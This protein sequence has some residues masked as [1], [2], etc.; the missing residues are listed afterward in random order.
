MED[1]WL[2]DS[3]R[4]G[5]HEFRY[6][7]QLPLLPSRY[8]IWFSQSVL[9]KNHFLLLVW[10]KEPIETLGRAPFSLTRVALRRAQKLSW[11]PLSG[12]C[13]YHKEKKQC[14][15][16]EATVHQKNLKQASKQS[17]TNTRSIKPQ[18]LQDSPFRAICLLQ[19]LALLSGL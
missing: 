17:K 5:N 3:R 19:D 14:H 10:E 11:G 9:E 12:P 13:R 18:W 4:V 2:S 6:Q 8:R 1:L 16:V 15:P 7:S